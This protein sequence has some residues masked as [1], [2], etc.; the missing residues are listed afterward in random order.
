MFN[1]PGDYP[2][3]ISLVAQ[4][5]IDLKRLV[6]HRFVPNSLAYRSLVKYTYRSFDFEDAIS[7]FQATRMGKGEDGKEVIKVIISGPDTPVN[8]N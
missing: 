7:A 1:Q 8:E 6:T 4:G 3:A 2:L 5:K